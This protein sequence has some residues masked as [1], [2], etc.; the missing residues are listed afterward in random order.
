MRLVLLAALSLLVMSCKS[1]DSASCGSKDFFSVW[2]DETQ[3][4]YIDF[5]GGSFGPT[6]AVYFDFGGGNYCN[7][8]IVGSGNQCAGSVAVTNS[9]HNGVGSDPGCA[10]L[11]GVATFTK[12]TNGLR[13]CDSGGCLNYD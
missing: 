9:T 3:S 12:S 11:N 2:L 10:S 5:R 4:F 1:G 6:Y 7:M 8:D 13:V